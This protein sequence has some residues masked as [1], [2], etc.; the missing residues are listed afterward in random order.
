MKKIEDLKIE[1]EE[2]L[3]KLEIKSETFLD[4]AKGFVFEAKKIVNEIKEKANIINNIPDDVKKEINIF[5]MSIKSKEE[6][7]MAIVKA[8]RSYLKLEQKLNTSDLTNY[9]IETIKLHLRKNFPCDYITQNNKA[10]KMIK[11]ILDFKKGDK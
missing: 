2:T 11:T 1:L 5:Y 7:A 9:E 8:R 6:K 3:E 10:N 4:E